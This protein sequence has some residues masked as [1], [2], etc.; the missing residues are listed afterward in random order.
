[1][2]PP[3]RLQ[4]PFHQRLVDRRQ[5]DGHDGARGARAGRGRPGRSL[6]MI[7]GNGLWFDIVRCQ[8]HV[9]TRFV[10]PLVVPDNQ[11]FLE[12]AHFGVA[13]GITNRHTSLGTTNSRLKKS[14]R[15]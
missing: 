12:G 4:F 14:V 2:A 10:A 7:Q 9:N 1:M 15:K 5:L 6:A 11:K 3:P 13:I 8:V